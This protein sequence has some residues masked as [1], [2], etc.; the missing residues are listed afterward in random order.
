MAGLDL[1]YYAYLASAVPP[2]AIA[3]AVVVKATRL[4]R[5]R[6][7]SVLGSP[8]RPLPDS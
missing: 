5:G 6:V 4:L 2:R 1:E 3:R 8:R 7:R